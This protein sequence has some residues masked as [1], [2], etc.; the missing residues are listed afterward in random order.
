MQKQ[1]LIYFSAL[2]LTGCLKTQAEIKLTKEN[3]V[4]NAFDMRY[5]ACRINVLSTMPDE[6]AQLEKLGI[7]RTVGKPPTLEQRMSDEFIPNNLKEPFQALTLGIHNCSDDWANAIGLILQTVPNIMRTQTNDY[8]DIQVKLLKR[9]ITIG[10]F[11][12]AR[13]RISNQFNAR[14]QMAINQYHQGINAA[15]QRE[16]DIV[17]Q[18]FNRLQQQ[19]QTYQQMNQPIQTNCTMI[20]NTANCFT[21]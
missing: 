9:E 11:I 13:E 15:H 3:E 17:G 8:T 12:S 5:K 7:L 10:K 1:L 2:L 18:S 4:R 16:L 21:Y 20:G 19:Q 6:V 14:Y